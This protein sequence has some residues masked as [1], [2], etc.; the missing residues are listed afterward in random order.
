MLKRLRD[1]QRQLVKG[2][3]GKPNPGFCR[4]C[5]CRCRRA[6][7][8]ESFPVSEVT[9]SA[10]LSGILR[11]VTAKVSISYWLKENKHLSIPFD[12]FDFLQSS[13][14]WMLSTSWLALYSFLRFVLKFQDR[15][16]CW[17]TL[18][19]LVYLGSTMEMALVPVGNQSMG[20][21]DSSG[22]SK[23]IQVTNIAPQ[24][25]RCD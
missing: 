6:A 1:D 4:H 15:F 22:N 13:T 16:F 5:C 18:N 9:K 23:V 12:K 24:A 10:D 14:W 3:N 17:M 19:F 25:T 8:W 21:S 20:S 11:S 7:L 2:G